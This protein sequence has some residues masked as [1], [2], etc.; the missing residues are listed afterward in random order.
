MQTAT[1]TIEYP[2]RETEPL[3]GSKPMPTTTTRLAGISR[4]HS[5]ETTPGPFCLDDQ[6]TP[7]PSP[8]R[9]RDGLSQTVVMK[10][11]VHFQILN[12]YQPVL[13]DYPTGM[14]MREVIPTPPGALVNAGYNLP[15]FPTG[16]RT[17]LLLAQKTL[18][19]SQ[20]LFLSTKEAWVLNLCPSREGSKRLQPNVYSHLLTRSGQGR[21]LPLTRERSVPL[22]RTGMSDTNCFG[23]TFYGAVQDYFDGTDFGQMKGVTYQLTAGWSLRIAHRVV[24][25]LAPETRRAHFLF[26]GLHSTKEGFVCKVYPNGNVLQHL[27]MNSRK[28]WAFL[29]DVGKYG[30]L[31]IQ[32]QSFATLLKRIL[33]LGKKVVIQPATFLKH[34]AHLSS[35]LTSRKYPVEK[36][37]THLSSYSTK[38]DFRQP[39][40]SL[41]TGLLRSGRCIPIAKARGIC[42]CESW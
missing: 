11:T 1:R 21:R 2:L 35:L 12:R 31:G 20:C 5:Y 28:C 39:E 16:V 23:N 13:V 42:V 15:T 25:A 38:Q 7:K 29:L 34:I 40:S 10:H 30:V 19:L 3:I 6:H 24:S 37:F 33:T 9:V 4:V 36:G 27:A 8:R 17:L 14:L 41:S 22:T 26:A 32:G 18:C